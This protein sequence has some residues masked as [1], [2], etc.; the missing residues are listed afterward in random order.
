MSPFWRDQHGQSWAD[1]RLYTWF[2]GGLALFARTATI[3]D[4]LF[5]LGLTCAFRPRCERPLMVRALDTGLPCWRPLGDYKPVNRRMYL[6]ISGLLTQGDLELL[7]RV[8]A[9]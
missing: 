1:D 2:D 8:T 4:C 3:W 6:Q 9:R 7:Q 5:H